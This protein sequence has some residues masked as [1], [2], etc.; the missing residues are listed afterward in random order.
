[1]NFQNGQRQEKEN[2]MTASQIWNH[3]LQRMGF[4][5]LQIPLQLLHGLAPEL[6]TK[7][8]DHLLHFS[9]GAFDLEVVF[10]QRDDVYCFQRRNGHDIAI[11]Q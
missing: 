4:S 5:L 9:A 1:V 6:L 7:F 2:E 10:V 8:A 3:M 11:Q